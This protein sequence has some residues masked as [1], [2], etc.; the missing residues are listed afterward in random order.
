MTTYFENTIA[1]L[2]NFYVLNMHVKYQHLGG[3]VS[4]KPGQQV[5]GLGFESQQLVVCWCSL[6]PFFVPNGQPNLT[7]REYGVLP[8]SN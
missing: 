4:K 3:L 8:G 6:Y 5:S 7:N 2:H 1:V